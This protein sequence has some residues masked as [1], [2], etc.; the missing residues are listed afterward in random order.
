[1]KENMEEIEKIIDWGGGW[2]TRALFYDSLERVLSNK[3][4]NL[5]LAEQVF[6]NSSG[7]SAKIYQ[8]KYLDLTGSTSNI[9]ISDYYSKNTK[10][11]INLDSFNQIPYDITS[12]YWIEKLCEHLKTNRK[13]LSEKIRQQN[14][15]DLSTKVD[16]KELI[17]NFSFSHISNL[18]P[19]D[20]KKNAFKYIETSTSELLW[21]KWYLLDSTPV[22]IEKKDL[23]LNSK[24]FVW[25]LLHNATHILHLINY[26]KSGRDINPHGL[27]NMEALAMNTEKE[28]LK[29]L[30]H[31]P[32][33]LSTIPSLNT[34]NVITQLLLGLLER[35]LRLEYDLAIHLNGQ[36]ISDWIIE[37]KRKTGLNIDIYSFSQEFHGLPGFSAGYMLGLKA[38]EVERDKLSIVKGEK[39]LNFLKLEN[40][41]DLSKSD[42]TDIPSKIPSYPIYIQSVG[43]VKN[44]TFFNL[45]NPFINQYVSVV[46]QVDLTVDLK[47]SQRGIHMSRLQQILESLYEYKNWETPQEISQYI[48][49]TAIFKQVAKRAHVSIEMDS[50]V[51]TFNQE[52][53]TNSRQPFTLIVET[54]VNEEKVINT[55]GMKISVMTACPCTLEFSRLKTLYSLKENFHNSFHDSVMNYIPPTF[56]HSQKGLL[57]VKVSSE[58]ELTSLKLLYEKIKDVAH[59]VE[60]VLKRPDEHFLVNKSHSK[61]Q[62]C[63]DL[64]REVAVSVSTILNKDDLICIEVE[65][66]ESIHP[67]KAYASLSLIASQ[68]W[69]FNDENI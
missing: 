51:N 62:F 63:E 6:K 58:K 52:S 34:F 12:D 11:V 41:F 53:K 36:N 28:F 20:N 47:A 57:T 39:Q 32:E 61:P 55:I 54:S 31:N 25:T 40:N 60:S 56:T 7:I 64:C 22:L 68:A 1:M 42:K 23:L 21:K 30:E 65:L 37:V 26:P 3:R 59:L 17:E 4:Q 44:K 66:D 33:T 48:A 67:H 27:L 29:I 2:A 13:E 19:L 50:F 10:K 69:C 15:E 43:T 24:S 49:Q 46:A 35:A 5:S 16:M 8:K 45:K 14:N 18:I 9:N 38:F